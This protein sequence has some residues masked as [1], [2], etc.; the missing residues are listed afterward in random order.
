MASPTTPDLALANLQATALTTRCHNAFF[1]QKQ[2]KSLHDTL[3]NNTSSIKDAIK[4]D[5]SCRVSDAEASIEVALAFDI[6]KEHY[7]FINV[8]KELEDEYRIT[9]VKDA[10]DRSEPCG[11]VYIE[12]QPNHTPFYSVIVALSA[13]L[14]AGSCVALKVR[15]L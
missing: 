1:R 5:T 6:V 15:L 9:N 10:S 3:R 11:V 4:Q 13:A 14:A 2:L 12:P 8:K 7:S